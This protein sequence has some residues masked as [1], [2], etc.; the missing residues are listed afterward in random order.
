[1]KQRIWTHYSLYL[2]VALL[3]WSCGQ[4]RRE[5]QALQSQTETI[6]DEAMKGI[7]DMNRIGR[8]LKEKLT[9]LDSIAPQRDSIYR[10]LTQMNR[11][12]E[13][14]QNWMVNY[15]APDNLPA[16]EALQYLQGQKQAIDK[17]LK[18]I[19]T[20]LSEARQLLGQ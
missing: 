6:H 3:T 19:E 10:I 7:A 11:A 20:A 5:V 9:A 17:N 15:K 2:L 16:A 4:N 14:M 18:D 8:Q 1:M 13:E 12:D